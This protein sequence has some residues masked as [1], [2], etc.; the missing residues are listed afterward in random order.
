MTLEELLYKVEELISEELKDELRAQGH[1]NTGALDQSIEGTVNG[2]S[3][4][5]YANYYALILHHGYGPE[6]ASMK[7]WPYLKGFF[8]SKGYEEKDAGQLAAMTINAW[9]REGMPSSGSF[10]YS[11]TGER[12]QF[13]AIVKKAINGKIDQTISNGLDK[14]VNKKF[15]ETKSETI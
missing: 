1:Y 12:T 5:G 11:E 7:Q 4:Q 13:I 3:L 10:T 9:K 2:N 14:I 8:L 6:K 15:N